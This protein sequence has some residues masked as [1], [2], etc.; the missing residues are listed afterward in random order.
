MHFLGLPYFYVSQ[1]YAIFAY[2]N[3]LL[4]LFV[5]FFEKKTLFVVHGLA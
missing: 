5:F 4:I 1:R 2:I 3:N